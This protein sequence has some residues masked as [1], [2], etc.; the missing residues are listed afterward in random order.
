MRAIAADREVRF[1]LVA[2]ELAVAASLINPYGMDLFVNTLTFSANPN[3]PDVLEWFPLGFGM[4]EGLVMCAS[5][6]MI[7]GLLRWSDRRIRPAE[8]LLIVVFSVLTIQTVRM[9]GWYAG[10]FGYCVLPHLTSVTARVSRSWAGRHVHDDTKLVRASARSI[11]N[12]AICA[13]IVWCGF[14]ISPISSSLLGGARREPERILNK[15]TPRELTEFLRRFQ[16][17][18]QVWN[19]QWWGDWLQW[20][21]PEGMQLFVTTNAVHLTPHRVWKDYMR[22]AQTKAGWETVLKRYNITTMVIHKRKEVSLDSEARILPGW[23]IVYEDELGLV[24]TREPRRP[25]EEHDKTP[26]IDRPLAKAS[27]SP[28]SLNHRPLVRVRLQP[29]RQPTPTVQA[30]TTQPP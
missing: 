20:Q 23:R 22:V 19:P 16:P 21:G 14:S 26:P 6:V 4:L 27:A 7:A 13:M 2:T 18:G 29:T 17:Q 9:I 8:L 11:A 10:V 15:E 25:F 24:V 12:T 28:D 1:W 30:A 5:W 3:L